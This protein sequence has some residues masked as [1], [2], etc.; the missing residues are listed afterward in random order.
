[1][2]L[3]RLRPYPRALP[4]DTQLLSTCLQLACYMPSQQLPSAHQQQARRETTR[5]SVEA[6]PAQ[7]PRGIRTMLRIF[8]GGQ[9]VAQTLKPCRQRREIALSRRHLRV[10][11]VRA[12]WRSIRIRVSWFDQ[13]PL[14]C[15]IASS[16]RKRPSGRMVFPREQR[17]RAHM[18][19]AGEP[20]LR[21]RRRPP[22]PLPQVPTPFWQLPASRECS[23]TSHP[24]QGSTTTLKDAG[25]SA[26]S[27]YRAARYLLP[28]HRVGRPLASFPAG[29][30]IVGVTQTA[31][32]DL[33]ARPQRTVRS[34]GPPRGRA[35]PAR[36]RRPRRV[37]RTNGETKIRTQ[38]QGFLAPG[39]CAGAG[40]ELEHRPPEIRV[41]AGVQRAHFARVW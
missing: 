28:R 16:G 20:N 32:K 6:C 18:G 2:P 13:D 33:H 7:S 10:G 27:C 22:T 29:S 21:L 24:S 23:W 39:A 19:G 26:A 11:T 15:E 14:W 40:T 17:K 36:P 30:M 12:K 35:R 41:R 38:K 9:Q 31:T 25:D 37:L 5:A 3:S 8:A 4:R 34:V 1:M